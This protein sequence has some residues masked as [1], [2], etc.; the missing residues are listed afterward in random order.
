MKITKFPHSCLKLEKDGRAIAIDIG[1]FTTQSTE[2]TDI[3]P[4]EAL[5]ITHRHPDHIDPSI[6]EWLEAN[7]I[8]VFANSDVSGLLP[9]FPMTTITDG[10]KFEAGGFRIEAR[11]LPH[12]KMV[13]GT[14]GPPNTGYVIDGLLFHPGDGIAI[15]DLSVDV[16][17]VPVAGPSVSLHTAANF[18]RQV[19]AQTAIP[20]HNDNPVFF[21]EPAMLKDRF[22]E[23]NIVVLQDG[24]SMEVN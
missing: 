18:I 7:N 2:L 10:Q 6:R 17:A 13:D 12:C 23:A 24:Q 3:G 20:I 19:G 1:I 14:D 21:N 5:L 15:E 11:D 16:L 9:D 8:S 4:I 22:R